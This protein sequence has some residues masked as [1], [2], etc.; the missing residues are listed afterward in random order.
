MIDPGT[1][2]PIAVPDSPAHEEPEDIEP[3]LMFFEALDRELTGARNE[4]GWTHP[5]AIE[6]AMDRRDITHE[7]HRDITRHLLL[8]IAAGRI[9]ALNETTERA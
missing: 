2:R 9:E 8:M 1:G 7:L 3:H 6:S 5:D 4:N